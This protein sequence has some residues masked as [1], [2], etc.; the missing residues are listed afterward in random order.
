MS[1]ESGIADFRSPGG[2]WE[3]FNPLKYANYTVFLQT[4]EYFWELVREM[5]PVFEK[6]KPNKGHK[7]LVRLEKKGKLSAIITQNI[8]NFHQAAGS[9]VPVVELHGNARHAHCMDCHVSIKQTYI[10]RQLKKTDTSV[11]ICPECGGR[12]KCDMILFNEPVADDLIEEATHYAESCD[13]ML[14]LGSSLS[15]FPAN[16]IPLLARKAGAKLIFINRDPSCY[17]KYATLRL[18]GNLGT[19]LP[20]IISEIK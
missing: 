1:T 19:Y 11:P 12:I 8:D 18:L 15:V 2:L 20:M 9:K 3:H 13:I 17:D 5:L 16:Q 7:A 10:A 6:A 14:I 4:P